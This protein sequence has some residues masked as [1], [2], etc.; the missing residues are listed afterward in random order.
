[1]PLRDGGSMG[2]TI[3]LGVAT[4]PDSAE[5]LDSLVDAAD[6]ALLRAKRAG[7]NQIRAAPATG[8]VTDAE[9]PAG[10]WKARGSRPSGGRTANGRK[11]VAGVQGPG[12]DPAI[13]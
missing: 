12:G 1:M 5:D 13:T 10:R 11:L 8:P 3:S 2:V 4:I 6:R 9:T 7:K